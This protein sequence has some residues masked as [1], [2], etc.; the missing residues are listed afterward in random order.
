MRRLRVKLGE[1]VHSFGGSAIPDD[2]IVE[3]SEDEAAALKDRAT[4]NSIE[5][6]GRV[7]S[8]PEKDPPA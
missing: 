6:V 1:N 4:R 3:L 7:E 8:Q 2:R 5:I